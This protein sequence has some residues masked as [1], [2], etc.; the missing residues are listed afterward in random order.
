MPSISCRWS[1]SWYAAKFADRPEEVIFYGNP[2]EILQ[3]LALAQFQI[4][5]RYPLADWHRDDDDGTRITWVEAFPC[6]CHTS[7]ET[8]LD[9]SGQMT[10]QIALLTCGNERGA[11]HEGHFKNYYSLK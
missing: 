6:F 9:Y 1:K 11:N 7:W 8:V 3:L 2:K 5:F 4:G 10:W